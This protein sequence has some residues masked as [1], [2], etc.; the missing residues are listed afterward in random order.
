MGDVLE[1]R[2][3]AQAG[4]DRDPAWYRV[5]RRA[6]IY[7]TWLLMRTGFRPNQV[8]ALMMLVGAAGA[9]L[10]AAS[11]RAAN[12]AG[13]VLVYVGFLLD[14]SDG[15]I[16]RLRGEQ[17]A[18]GIL[19]D[20]FHHRVIEPGLFAAAAIHAYRT[21]PSTWVLLSGPVIMLLANMIEENQHIAPYIFYKRTREGGLIGARPPHPRLGLER[22]A[23]VL[24]PLKGFRMLIVALPLIYASYLLEPVTGFPVTAAYLGVSVAALVLYFT[25]QCVFYYAYQLD[26]ELAEEAAMHERNG[27]SERLEVEATRDDASLAPSDVGSPM[28]WIGRHTFRETHASPPAPAAVPTHGKKVRP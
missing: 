9:I 20:R 1:M 24:K 2:Q 21:L 13:F 27:S 11:S 16:A 12:F 5:H 7:V 26:A 8:S 14:K 4:K 15:E 19:L 18:R 28:N 23:R 3:V 6:S 10:M 22:L 25:F 17:T